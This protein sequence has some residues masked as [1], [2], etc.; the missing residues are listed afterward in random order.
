MPVVEYPHTGGNTC[1]IGGFVYRGSDIPGLAG[2]Y[3]YTDLSGGWLRSFVHRNGVA[4]DAV[5]WNIVPP[6][7]PLS[8]G[9]D[10]EGELYLLTDGGQVYRL[11]P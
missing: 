7:S 8:F 2:H 6:D 1:V 10:A 3:F 11:A 5:D 4:D 9:E